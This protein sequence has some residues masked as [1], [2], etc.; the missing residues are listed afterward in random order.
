MLALDNTKQSPHSIEAEQMLLACVLFDANSFYQINDLDITVFYRKEHQF[1]FSAMQS[2]YNVKQEI[3]A[4]TLVSKLTK[5][6]LE[7]IG[8]VDYINDLVEAT[9]NSSNILSYKAIL[10]DCFNLRKL[11]KSCEDLK[12]NCYNPDGLDVQ[13]ILTKHMSNFTLENDNNKDKIYN[14][15]DFV[16]F[17][18]Q[19]QGKKEEYIST[20][21]NYM[22]TMLNGGFG[23]GE[24]VIIAGKS[25]MGKT[26][27]AINIF[28]NLTKNNKCIYFSLEMT[29]NEISKRIYSNLMHKNLHNDLTVEDLDKLYLEISTRK[30]MSIVDSTSFNIAKLRTFIINYKLKNDGLDVVVIDYLQIMGRKPKQTEY[31]A[32]SEITRELK[33]IAMEFKIVIICLSQLNRSG[34]ERKEKRPQLTDLRGSGSI[35]QDADIVMFLHREEWYYKELGHGVPIDIENAIELIISKFRRHNPN[36]MLYQCNLKYSY[37]EPMPQLLKTRYNDFFIKKYE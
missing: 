32:L 35:E 30:H 28:T 20:N 21:D 6:Q 8:G 23:R 33:I 18:Q 37:L 14:V 4:I 27:T 12:D 5:E 36:K 11:I 3:D 7:F 17:I 29:F 16:A 24:L 1:I 25:G 19:S 13:E 9:S 34:A 31:E 22:D 10:I 15:T 26:A 2:I